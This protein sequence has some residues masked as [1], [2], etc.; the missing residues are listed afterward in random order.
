[1]IKRLKTLEHIKLEWRDAF[2]EN[3]LNVRFYD[4]KKKLI[5]HITPAM[6]KFFG[7]NIDV[8]KTHSNYYDWSIEDIT[9]DNNKNWIWYFKD[10]WFI[11]VDLLEDELFEI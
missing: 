7:T 8:K 6:R 10:D 4:Y 5:A 11:D 1:M 2:V 9:N 3:E